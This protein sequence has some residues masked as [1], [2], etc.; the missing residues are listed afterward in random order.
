[1][2]TN[3]NREEKNIVEIW[4]WHDGWG[5]SCA[6]KKVNRKLR[7]NRQKRILDNAIQDVISKV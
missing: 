1:M 4:D 5:K 3:P 2:L 7:R 6:T